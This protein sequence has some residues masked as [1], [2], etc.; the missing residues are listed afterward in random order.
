LQTIR[1]LCTIC[2]VPTGVFKDEDGI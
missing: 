1:A 2:T